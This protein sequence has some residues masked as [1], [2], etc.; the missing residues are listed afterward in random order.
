M[1][2][3]NE[4]TPDEKREYMA[5]GRV[6]VGR[7]ATITDNSIKVHYVGKI[8]GLIVSCQ[9]KYKFETVEDARNA[10]LAMRDYWQKQIHDKKEEG[11]PQ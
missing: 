1:K 4:M 2:K 7:I 6:T 5:S 3:Y 11:S 10:A 9:D 8:R